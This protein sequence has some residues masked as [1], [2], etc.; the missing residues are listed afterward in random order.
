MIFASKY[1]TVL[2]L[3]VLPAAIATNPNLK[4]APAQNLEEQRQMFFQWMQEHGKDYPD[5][6]ELLGRM[7]VWLDNHG[8]LQDG[9]RSTVFGLAKKLHVTR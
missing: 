2:A 3:A 1:L 6:Q 8:M 5:S 9:R 7:N 4:G